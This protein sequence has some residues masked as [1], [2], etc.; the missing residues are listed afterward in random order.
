MTDDLP[1]WR[2]KA[3]AE[4]TREEWESLCDGCG[5]CCL[6]KLQDEDTDEIALTDVACRL[7]DLETCHCGDY[8]NRSI[9]VPDCVQLT[10]DNA[11][12]LNWMPTTCGYRRLAN[13]KSLEWWHPLVS[14]DP[15]TVH[16]AGFSIRGQAVSEDD[17]DDIQEH[18]V[19]WLNERLKQGLAPLGRG[20]KRKRSQK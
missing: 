12:A 20:R 4:M 7:L 18:V 8:P 13:G 17:I 15:E 9:H 5:Q 11:G 3:L 6:H 14:G 16:A 1:F 10:P 19:D 2:T